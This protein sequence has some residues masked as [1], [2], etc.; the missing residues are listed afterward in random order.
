M[1]YLLLFIIY[2]STIISSLAS[3]I[4][5]IKATSEE[6]GKAI[7]F[8]DI[9]IKGTGV[10][11]TDD[12]GIA[13]V[14]LSECKGKTLTVSSY[15]H[16]SKP[17]TIN[18]ETSDTLIV[19][20]KE[21]SLPIINEDISKLKKD[22]KF[23]IGRTKRN[24]HFFNNGYF[25]APA[26]IDSIKSKAQPYELG[27]Q[28]NAPE[29]KVNV[30]NAFGI[31][32]LPKDSMFNQLNFTLYIYDVTGIQPGDSLKTPTPVYKPIPVHYSIND[33]NKKRKEFRYDFPEP[34]ILPS[35]TV[36]VV[37]W[38]YCEKDG[39]YTTEGNLLTFLATKTGE[40]YWEGNPYKEYNPPYVGKKKYSPYFWE[41]S[42]YSL[43]E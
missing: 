41:Y 16:L 22:K 39:H 5:T 31:N 20:M 12:A 25:T 13:K 28:I 35:K 2:I 8:T 36:I 38:S 37:D 18:E 15:G 10:V 17:F 21:T 40:W 43:P 14:L 29:G 34:L 7:P 6:T 19:R 4:L 27:V 30:L 3:D 24:L 9:I 32:I 42:Q 23:K 11:H 1:K 33:V 26:K